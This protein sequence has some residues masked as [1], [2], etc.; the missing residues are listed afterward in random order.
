MLI[1]TFKGRPR[2]SQLTAN[3]RTE[4]SDRQSISITYNSNQFEGK[5][6]K[7]R[8]FQHIHTTEARLVVKRQKKDIDFPNPRHTSQL[9]GR[10]SSL[11]SPS[12]AAISSLTASVS[13]T[14]NTTCAPDF[15]KCLSTWKRP[16]LK[17]Y[18]FHNTNVGF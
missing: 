12:H 17:N 16:P 18:K 10:I 6:H 4:S 3:F 7:N 2:A 1:S 13:A 8:C 9:S 14:A 5:G 11:S 15:A